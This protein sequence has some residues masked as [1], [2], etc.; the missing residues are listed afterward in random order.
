MFGAVMQN[1]EICRGVLEILLGVKIDHVEYPELQKSISPYYSQ[2][3][4]RLD[5]YIADSDRIFDVKCQSYRIS[6]IGKRTRYYQAMLD[7]DN[8]AK[9]ADYSE[10]KESYVIFICLDDPFV[11][12][13]PRYTF[14]KKCMESGMQLGI[15][16]GQGLIV[17]NMFLLGKSIA[18]ISALTELPENEVR[19]LAENPTRQ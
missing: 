2:K 18:E 14:E 6:D 16:Q 3:G 12:G 13:L 4:V 5:V 1:P 17:R 7:I 10:L 8:L 15:Q 9:G 11:K 19:I